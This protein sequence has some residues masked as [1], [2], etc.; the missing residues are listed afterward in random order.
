M[1]RREGFPCRPWGPGSLLEGGSPEAGGP[2]IQVGIC[3]PRKK[4]EEAPRT[5]ATWQDPLVHTHHPTQLAV[6]L[7]LGDGV[8]GLTTAPA[9]L[10]LLVTPGLRGLS[11]GL[12]LREANGGSQL[13]GML[14]GWLC[15]TQTMHM[16]CKKLDVDKR[17]KW[18]PHWPWPAQACSP[19]A[20]LLSHTVSF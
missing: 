10:F 6:V 14:E 4:T 12:K 15:D 17:M 11:P 16:Q 13:L 7:S 5:W 2:R 19:E 1:G 3:V 8:E 9:A 18:K 20:T